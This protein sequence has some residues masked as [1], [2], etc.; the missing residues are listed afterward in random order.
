[1]VVGQLVLNEQ[2]AAAALKKTKAAR[3]GATQT[4]WGT[5]ASVAASSLSTVYLSRDTGKNI[6]GKS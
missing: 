1:M 4:A 2:R 5:T 3:T 6:V